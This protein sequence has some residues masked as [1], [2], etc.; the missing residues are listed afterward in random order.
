MD[1]EKIGIGVYPPRKYGTCS[2]EV[3]YYAVALYDMKCRRV[4][5]R[6]ISVPWR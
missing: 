5:R 4:L 6:W 2:G 3:K 1:G